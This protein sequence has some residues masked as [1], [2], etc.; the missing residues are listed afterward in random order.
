[1]NLFFP[2]KRIAKHWLDNCLV[3]RGQTYPAQLMYQELA[4]LACERITAAI[5]RTHKDTSPD[6][7]PTGPVQSLRLNQVS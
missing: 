7:G 1:M 2:L 6:Q 4:D 3:C 5:T